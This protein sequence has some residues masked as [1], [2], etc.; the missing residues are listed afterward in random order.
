MIKYTSTAR[1]PEWLNKKIS[2]RDCA[3]VKKTLRSSG[4]NTVCEE[5]ACPNISECFSRKT[6]TFMIL[7][8]NCTRTC[9]FC[10]VTKETPG[11]LDWHEPGRVAEAVVKFGLRHVVVTSVTRDDLID[12]GAL[13]FAE[14]IRAI[15]SAQKDARIE[16]L[17]PDL[18]AQEAALKVVVHARPDILNHNIETVP[19]L[20]A[21]VR[22]E[23]DYQRSLSVLRMAKELT[24]GLRM[25]TKSGVM[26]GM[27]E[28]EEEVLDV[29]SD[30]R[31]VD[32][33]FLSIGQYLAPS[34]K[35]YQVK[36]YIE[37]GKFDEYKKRTLDMGFKY[38]ASGPYVR[39]SYL[40][41]EYTD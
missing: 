19:R 15:R 12:G 17:I 1:K 4:L 22:P 6:A 7:G 28:T 26:L 27:G 29:L 40:A 32:C 31:D 3:Q 23:A 36:E 21:E 10:N 9:K 14:T 8:D 13:V 16:V 24:G 39:S 5:A 11:I 2:L 41:H 25:N 30:L 20:Y 38:V 34:T 33:D 35:H 37:P 18:K